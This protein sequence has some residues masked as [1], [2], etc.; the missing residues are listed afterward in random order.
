MNRKISTP[1][2]ILVYREDR[3]VALHAQ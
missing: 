1:M 2:K 3:V